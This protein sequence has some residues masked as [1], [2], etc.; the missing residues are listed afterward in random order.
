MRY[1]QRT[2]TFDLFS[3]NLSLVGIKTIEVQAYFKDYPLVTSSA[4]NPTETIQIFD[5][6]ERPTGL[7][8]PGQTQ[9]EYF[10]SE[11]GLAY[12]VNDFVPSPSFCP[13]TYECV[14]SNCLLSELAFKSDGSLRF[15][16]S[17]L[18][19][20]PPGKIEFTLRGSVG[21]LVPKTID[22]SIKIILVDPCPTLSA[23]YVDPAPFDEMRYTLGKP[24]VI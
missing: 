16:T 1:D 5:P 18:K 10:Y 11:G 6:C 2:Q 23:S 24:D 8:D 9:T 22:T 3:E 19:K 20:F 15:T 17:D 21:S 14:S 4:P 12:K 7:A 13:V